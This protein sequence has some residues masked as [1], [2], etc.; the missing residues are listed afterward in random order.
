LSQRSD[1]AQGDL[2]EGHRAFMFVKHFDHQ[3]YPNS[4]Q[5]RAPHGSKD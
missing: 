1:L 2:G 4:E 3:S 5:R